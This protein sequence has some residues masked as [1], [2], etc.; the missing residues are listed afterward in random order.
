MQ[1]SERLELMGAAGSPYSRKM[2]GVLRYKHLPYS[3]Y[4]GP[5]R[6]PEGYPEPKVRLF[7]TFYFP[8]GEDG[9]PVAVTDSTPIIRRLEASHPERSVLPGDPVLRFLNDLIE[10]YGDE[11]LTKAMFHFRWAREVD[12]K[13]AAPLLVYWGANMTPPDQADEFADFFA[14]RQIERLYVVGSNEVTAE[15]IEASYERFIGILDGLVARKGFVLGARPSSADFALYGQ[16]TQLAIIEPT[17]AAITKRISPRVRAWVDLM[18]DLSGLRPGDEDWVTVEDAQEAL[19][20][21]IAEIGRTYAPAMAAN[22]KAVMA[23]DDTFETVIDDKPWTQPV[24]KYQAKCLGWLR[25]DHA[26]LSGNER[27]TVDSMLAGSGCD[28]LFK[29]A[30]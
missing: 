22:A 30:G 9:A 7:P 11:W 13:N 6:V 5:G 14:K 3:V 29:D 27:G 10:D 2:L 21:L 24:F 16:L 23:G 25:D 28:T 4:W 1:S 20:P 26:A 15:T 12:W 18:E 8:D 19:A 17:S